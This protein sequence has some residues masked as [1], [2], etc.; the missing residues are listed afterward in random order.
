MSAI[1]QLRA[2]RSTTRLRVKRPA[3]P[4]EIPLTAKQKRLIRDSFRRIEPALELVG[5][6]FY[7]RL[8]RIDSSLRAR[9]DGPV[10]VQAR[11]FAAAVK[12]GMISL[13][14]KDGLGP[15]LKLLGARHRQLGIRSR[16]Y[17][18]MT[19]ALIW[20]LEQ[21]LEESFTRETKDAWNTLLGQ[22]MRVLSAKQTLAA[23]HCEAWP[24]L[25]ASDSTSFTLMAPLSSTASSTSCPASST[26]VLPSTVS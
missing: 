9:F 8:F 3:A 19:R 23:D 11:K 24:A 26:W 17:R 10:E 15:V 22:I 25:P 5:R 18:S 21:S 12:L 20:T 4:A 1:I 13:K 16:H 14:H 2:S 6:L 7:L